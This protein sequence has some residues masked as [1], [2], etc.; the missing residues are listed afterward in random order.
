MRDRAYRRSARGLH[1]LMHVCCASH[2]RSTY[3]ALAFSG[4]LRRH[5]PERDPDLKPNG[6]IVSDP[7][8]RIA[9][10][11]SRPWSA[12]AA[13]IA[14]HDMC[15]RCGGMR[16]ACNQMRSVFTHVASA[17]NATRLAAHGGRLSPR[18]GT[19]ST[20]SQPRSACT[21]S[22]GRSASRA[23]RIAASRRRRAS[24][25]SM[26]LHPWELARTHPEASWR[27]ESRCTRG[28][29]F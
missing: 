4:K 23:R 17:P 16:R 1:I 13:S 3:F 9:S 18:V 27:G 26:G 19:A 14:W 2:S 24:R 28:P 7:E 12:C 15:M 21:A 22:C 8:L 5:R 29:Q 20:C 11:R 6:E 25:E 10:S